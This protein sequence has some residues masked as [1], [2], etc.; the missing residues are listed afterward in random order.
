MSKQETKIIEGVRPYLAAG[1]EPLVAIVAQ[2]K[3][4]TKA[5]AGAGRSAPR[6]RRWVEAS[7]EPRTR[8]PREQVWCCRARV[9]SF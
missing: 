2:P 4:T 1:E 7:G 8:P 3:G 9:R 6:A 5:A